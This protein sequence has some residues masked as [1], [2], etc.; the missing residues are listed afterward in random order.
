MNKVLPLSI[1]SILLTASTLLAQCPVNVDSL[2]SSMTSCYG[3]CNGSATV[4][5]SGPGNLTYQWYDSN[6]LP[7]SGATTATLTGVC[8]GD[9]TVEV[10]T[11]NGGSGT[12]NVYEETFDGTQTWTLTNATGTNA[13]EANAWVITDDEGGVQPP[14]CGI[15]DN[16]D[17]TLHMTT[18]LLPGLGAAYNAGGGCPD[19]FCVETNVRAQSGMI[20]TVGY[21]GLTLTFDFIS[22]G[23]G[24]L[25]NASVWY[26]DGSGWTQLTASIKSVTCPGT[27]QGEWTEYSE[28]LPASCNNISNLQVGINWTNNDDGLGSDPSIAVNDVRVV[29]TAASG[30]C[31][32][33]SDPVSILEPNEVFILTQTTSATSCETVSNGTITFTGG[34]GTPPFGFSIDGGNDFSNTTGFFNGLAAGMY[35][36]ALEDANGCL[37]SVDSISVGLASLPT[38]SIS[39]ELEFC[40]GDSVSLFAS[41]GFA[42]YVWMPG[43]LFGQ[44]LTVSQGGAYIVVGIDTAGCESESAPVTVIEHENPEPMVSGDTVICDSE[45]TI[46][47]AGFGYTSYEWTPG[48]ETTQTVDVPAGSYT[49]T[50]VDF[51]GCVGSSIPTV[52]SELQYTPIDLQN[53]GDSLY[54]DPSIGTGFQW[55][56]NGSPIPGGTGT[57]IIAEQSGGYTLYYIDQYGCAHFTNVLDHT[58]INVNDPKM[59]FAIYPNPAIDV[60]RVESGIGQPIDGMDIHI[61]AATGRIMEACKVINGSPSNVDVSGLQAGVYLI[62]IEMK[63]DSVVKRVMISR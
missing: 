57:S 52:V 49:V 7:I 63:G 30:P 37:S 23:D 6:Q 59:Q 44:A 24:L 11:D 54:A 32:V 42:S 13:A 16:G 61:V 29:A 17:A 12:V 22:V 3:S 60:L 14:G 15:A 53:Y 33:T 34:G 26:N 20:S 36:L 28:T 55:H 48:G 45:T 5:A 41:N 40:E 27:G 2:T 31:T 50:V 8:A 56:L 1:A 58:Y 19:F 4:F 35:G 10:T 25:D 39:G 62:K 43:V 21:S 47:N 46:L 51:H 9:Y 18:P 38:P